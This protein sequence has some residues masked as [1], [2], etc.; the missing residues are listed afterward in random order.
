MRTDR[1]PCATAA[2]PMRTSP[3]ITTVPV[4]SL[5]TTRAVASMFTGSGSS[6]AMSSARLSL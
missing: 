5:I 3:P 1:L 2:A 6:R 4:R